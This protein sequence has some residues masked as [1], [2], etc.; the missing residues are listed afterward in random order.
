MVSYPTDLLTGLSGSFTN[1]QIV[2]NWQF[3]VSTITAFNY[4]QVDSANGQPAPSLLVS[5]NQNY[6]TVA[7]YTF[8]TV[9]TIIDA[10]GVSG[11]LRLAYGGNANG[12][13]R[14]FDSAGVKMADIDTGGWDV[15]S[16]TY[17]LN[18]T[19]SPYVNSGSNDVIFTKLN[20]N[21]LKFKLTCAN[22]QLLYQIGDVVYKA[23]IMGGNWKN[24]KKIVFEGYGSHGFT[25][26]VDNFKFGEY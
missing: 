7:T 10:W 20:A 4:I 8:P 11:N 3:Q 5:H 22:G 26:H 18:G 6:T 13:I 1:N 24:I 14:V 17:K 9:P 15:G 12:C 21:W 2:G 16:R 23:N 19:Y 25:I